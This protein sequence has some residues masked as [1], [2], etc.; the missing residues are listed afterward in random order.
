MQKI[1]SLADYDDDRGNRI[2]YGG[3]REPKV[4]IR[5]GK[6]ARN[7]VVI[8]PAADLRNILVIFTGDDGM[9]EIGPTTVKRAG[10]RMNL[11][12]GYRSTIRIGRN[13]GAA[14]TAFLSATEGAD[15]TV[16]DDV[17]FAKDVEVRT[18]DTHAIYDVR[19]G[20]RKNPSESI[21]VGA[22][23]WLAKH[24]VVMGGVVIGDGSVVGFR[25]IVTTSIPNN[26]VAVGAPARVVSTDVAWERPET[27][28]RSP[29]VVWP[30]PGQKSEQFWNLTTGL[31]SMPEPSVTSPRSAERSS[32][33][34]LSSGGGAAIAA[35]PPHRGQH[36]GRLLHFA[37]RVRNRARRRAAALRVPTD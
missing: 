11:R 32:K 15:V 23:V 27:P 34:H 25:S 33:R 24:V 28:N 1:E 9:V 5:F 14:G 18:D 13:V 16:G 29:D 2:R 35:P 26:C 3:A 7:R 36:L 6:G 19:T 20:V 8:D 10:I 4:D 22:H 17:M 37:R 12:V 30:L 21:V 31:D